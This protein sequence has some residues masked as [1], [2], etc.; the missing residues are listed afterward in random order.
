MTTMSGDNTEDVDL[1]EDNNDELL[2][3]TDQGQND[4]GDPD[5]SGDSEGEVDWKA[6][7]LKAEGILTRKRNQ[8]KKQQP[9]VEQKTN[10]PSV[11]A[12]ELRLLAKGYSDDAIAQAKAIAKG[13][14]ITVSEALK[15]PLFESYEKDVKE[16][17]KRDKAKLS[18]SKGSGTREEKAFKPGMT[19][20][21]H[22]AMFA[23]RMG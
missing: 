11:D 13:K 22:K 10:Q 4:A 17:E 16:K 2:E 14:G 8:A 19:R 15:D 5:D 23:Q 18:A 9:A 7:A 20:E 3:S 12:D 6:R 1:E 21:E